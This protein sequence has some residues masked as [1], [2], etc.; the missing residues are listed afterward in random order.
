MGAGVFA[1][2]GLVAVRVSVVRV[3]DVLAGVVLPVCAGAGVAVGAVV[4]EPEGVGVPD[5]ACTGTPAKP[6]TTSTKI[7]TVN[8]ERVFLFID[9]E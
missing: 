7:G 9:V 8:M 4:V 6:T 5:C 1:G 3:V 2:V